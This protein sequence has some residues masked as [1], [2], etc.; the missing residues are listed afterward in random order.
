MGLI[1]QSPFRGKIVLVLTV[2]GVALVAAVFF[3]DLLDLSTN[4]YYYTLNPKAGAV[5]LEESYKQNFIGAQSALDEASFIVAEMQ[6]NAYDAPSLFYYQEQ[7]RGLLSKRE[8]YFVE[9]LRID[10]EAQ[11]L[12]LGS[13]YQEFFEKRRA[14][15]QNDYEAFK[16]Y[17]DGMQGL[18]DGVLS[19]QKFAELYQ[20]AKAT[21]PPLMTPEGYTSENIDRLGKAAADLSFH[22]IELK[23]L[24]ERGILTDNLYQAIKLDVEHYDLFYQFT[25]KNLEHDAEGMDEI[26][27]QLDRIIET[28]RAD[29][30]DLLLEWAEETRQ[31]IFEAQDNKHRDSLDLYN[32]A[33]AYAENKGLDPIL[34]VWRDDHPGTEAYRSPI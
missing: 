27:L 31:P 15:D 23:S 28:E 30:G 19:Y 18:M 1:K 10:E 32:Q 16:I 4:L 9:M 24:A 12:R 11:G 17:R 3:G 2:L 25:K 5:Y 20:A 26:A 8:A 34:S 14:A 7:I 13:E 33:Y 6:Q 21:L 22:H 29:T